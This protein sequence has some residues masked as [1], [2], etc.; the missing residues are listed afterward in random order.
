MAFEIQNSEGTIVATVPDGQVD[1]TTTSITFI[2]RRFSDF[3]LSFNENNLFLLENFANS[4]PPTNPITG[5]LWFDKTPGIESLKVYINDTVGWR[6]LNFTV[7]F[8]TSN[9]SENVD[10]TGEV[11]FSSDVTANGLTTFNEDITINASTLTFV[12]SF[13]A[14]NPSVTSQIT[15]NEQATFNSTVVFNSSFSFSSTVTFDN[16]ATFT[17]NFDIVDSDVDPTGPSSGVKVFSKFSG[18]NDTNTVLLFLLPG[19]EGSTVI[20]DRAFGVISNGGSNPDNIFSV[21]GGAAIG[22]YRRKYGSGSL[23]LDG[24]G[25]YIQITDNANFDFSTGEFV[26]DCWVYPITTG[27]QHIMSKGSSST[28]QWSLYLDASNQPVFEF[29]DGTNS[30]SIVSPTPV[31]TYDWTHVAIERN[32]FTLTADFDLYV[33]GNRVATTNQTIGDFDFDLITGNIEIGRRSYGTLIASQTQTNFDGVS[34]NGTFVGGTGYVA[35]DTITLNDGSTITVNTQS[36]GAVTEFTVTAASTAGFDD[37][38]PTLT[39]TA[40]SGSG[41]GFTL[42]PGAANSEFLYFTG[43]FDDVRVVKGVNKYGGGFIPR[44]TPI[45][46]SDDLFFTN[47]VNVPLQLVHQFEVW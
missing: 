19:T 36:G 1:N 32:N 26:I 22:T 24:D 11:T 45:T 8:S 47:S 9:V 34:P 7:D 43:N 5:Q 39:Q 42:T 15:F 35:S 31:A 41:T 40:T 4:S 33:R 12:D 28:D 25:D 10:F 6:P 3:G 29:N 46:D 27:A 2:G 16:T 23:Q 38:L 21:N 13:I 37:T 44:R 20:N 18:G 30:F 17:S 14:G